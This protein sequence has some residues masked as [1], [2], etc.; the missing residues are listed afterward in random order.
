MK[1]NGVFCTM[2]I[3]FGGAD[4]HKAWSKMVLPE[5]HALLLERDIET[6]DSELFE[7]DGELSQKTTA[8]RF[9]AWLKEQAASRV[10]FFSVEESNQTL[11]VTG[12]VDGYDDY[13]IVQIGFHLSVAAAHA[14][15]IAG[16]TGFFADRGLHDPP[17]YNGLSTK[18]GELRKVNLDPPDAP[19]GAADEFCAFFDLS[20][21]SFGAIKTAYEHWGSP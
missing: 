7:E 18:D 19:E 16:R 20:D 5:Q 15:G 8:K 6:E 4:K 10:R 9:I 3:E 13:T 11:R 1:N 21:A 2:T 17:V 14:C 12:Y